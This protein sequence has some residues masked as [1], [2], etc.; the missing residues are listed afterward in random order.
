MSAVVGHVAI[1]SMGVRRR[2]FLGQLMAIH[3]VAVGFCNCIVC[4]SGSVAYRIIGIVDISI[5]A[6]GIG[7]SIEFVIDQCLTAAACNG[8]GNAGDVVCG[9]VGVAQV[10]MGAA[11]RGEN[12]CQAVVQVVGLA[13]YQIVAIGHAAHGAEG[14]PGHVAA[15]GDAGCTAL[16]CGH[17]ADLPQCVTGVIDCSPSRIGHLC[18]LVGSIV[19]VTGGLYVAADGRGLAT[20]VASC[21]VAV[22]RAATG[23][24]HFA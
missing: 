2:P 18:Q 16:F 21:S 3:F 24:C 6:G 19:G 12:L 11:V 7:Q 4:F 17:A 20:E 13:L 14:F 22:G 1:G 10:L 5:V 23:I 15:D 8:I 9:I